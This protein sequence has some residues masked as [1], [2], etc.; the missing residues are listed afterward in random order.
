MLAKHITTLDSCF[1][2]LDREKCR[3][4]AMDYA[5]MNEIKTPDNWTRDGMAGKQNWQSLC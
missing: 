1:H 5:V 2:G 4:L 3:K